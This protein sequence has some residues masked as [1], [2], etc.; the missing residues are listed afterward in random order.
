MS[1]GV[2][3]GPARWLWLAGGCASVVVGT[4]GIVVPGLPT[5]GFFV[6]AASCFARSSPRFEAWVLRLPGIG[7]AVRD[8]RDG[9][10]MARRAKVMAVSSIVIA[11]G[12]SAGLA[13]EGVAR[14]VVLALG[15]VGVWFV[16][17]HIPT[18]ERVLALRAGAG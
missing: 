15:A 8:Y 16:G 13:L 4:I 2:R 9:L 1:T 14:I 5:T 12:L 11:V 17:W 7:P 18:R 10:G 3:R 6:L